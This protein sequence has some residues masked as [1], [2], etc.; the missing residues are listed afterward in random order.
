MPRGGDLR[1][2]CGWGTPP[3]RRCNASGD[4]P[5]R[6]TSTPGRGGHGR[7]AHPVDAGVITASHATSANGPWT[8]LA[9]PLLRARPGKWDFFVTN[10]S[11]HIFDNGTV[12]MAYRGGNQTHGLCCGGRTGAAVA[13]SWRAPFERVS[14]GPVYP[15]FNEDPG[16]FAD[17]RGNM[18]IISHYWKDG[19]GGHAFSADGRSWS[20]AGQAYGFGI[21]YTNGR[22]GT[23]KTRERPQVVSVGGV[24]AFLFTGVTPQHGLSHTQAQPINR[25]ARSTY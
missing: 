25:A 10:P 16:L 24:P 4:A 21:N 2:G 7:L 23:V 6:A 13:S 18:H 20:F 19:P 5:L 15:D 3:P 17:A 9:R 11:V 1:R 14:D 8:T 22:S 12:L